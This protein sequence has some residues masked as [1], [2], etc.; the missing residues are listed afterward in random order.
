MLRVTLGI[1]LVGFLMLAAA[2]QR[3]EAAAA[4]TAPT[5]APP[6]ASGPD[7]LRP[8]GS[9]AGGHGNPL[10]FPSKSRRSAG[11]A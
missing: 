10:G 1:G 2:Y 3:P 6:I 7:G 4:P 5:G 8:A 9:S 11:S